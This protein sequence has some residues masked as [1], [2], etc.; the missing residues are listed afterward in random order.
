MSLSDTL[1][2]SQEIIAI[3]SGVV[4]FFMGIF[5]SFLC[6]LIITKLYMWHRQRILRKRRQDEEEDSDVPVPPSHVKKDSLS[7]THVKVKRHS[8]SDHSKHGFIV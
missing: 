7:R 2:V 4:A 5:L 1:G 6:C 3:S 8:D